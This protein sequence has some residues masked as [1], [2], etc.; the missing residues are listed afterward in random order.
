MTIGKGWCV[1]A[2]FP[3]CASR[4]LGGFTTEEE[5]RQWIERQSAAW[6]KQYEGGRYSLKTD[7]PTGGQ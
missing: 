1:R 3:D 7:G 5:A 6:L 2:T 4:Q